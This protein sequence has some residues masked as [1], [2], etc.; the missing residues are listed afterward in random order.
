MAV[1]FLLAGAAQRHAVQ[2]RDVVFHHRGLAD[3]DAGGVVDHDAAAEPGGGMDVDAEQFGNAALEKQRHALALLGPQPVGDAIAFE[4]MDPLEE[5][6][7]L[8][9]GM[10]GG[11]ALEHGREVGAHRLADGGI[12]VDRLLE[13]LAGEHRVQIFAADLLG[14]VVAE[15]ILQPAMLEDGGVHETRQRRLARGQILGLLA[16]GVPDRIATG[17]F[18]NPDGHSSLP[19]L[20]IYPKAGRFPKRWSP[21]TYIGGRSHPA[22]VSFA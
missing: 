8:D 5:Q 19:E 13:D 14:E 7:R 16:Q 6:E 11:I 4:R 21:W 2:H 3:D 22:T 10:A 12:G 1:A 9:M 15:R 18:F 20:L 17:D